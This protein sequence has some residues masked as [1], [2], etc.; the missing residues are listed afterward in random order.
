MTYSLIAMDMDGTF[1]DENGNVPPDFLTLYPKLRSLGL[2]FTPSS[3]RQLATLREM[4][5][6]LGAELNYIAENGAVVVAA[7]KIVDTTSLAKET[8]HRVLAAVQGYPTHLDLVVCEPEMAYLIPPQPAPVHKY[9]HAITHV[10]DL[11]AVIGDNIIKLAIYCP[12]DSQ[13]VAAAFQKLVPEAAVVASAPDWVDIMHPEANKGRALEKL[14][15]ALDI[16]LAETIA[17]G[18][19]LNDYELLEVAGTSYA[20]ANAHPD[21]LAIADHI[22]PANTENGVMRVLTE[23][24]L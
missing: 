11:A 9:Y 8:V 1:L 17:F 24:L 10:S 19:Y 12:A 14:S 15:A 20:M 23:L 13:A 6:H 18:D 3:G 21:L 22:A 7:G 2:S 4:F 16:P 5:G